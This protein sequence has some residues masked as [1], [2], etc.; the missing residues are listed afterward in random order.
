MVSADPPVSPP[1]P[2]AQWDKQQPDITSV[3]P[4]FACNIVQLAYSVFRDCEA[5]LLESTAG[6]RM[7]QQ[8]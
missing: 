5:L 3:S 7:A 6:P 8:R 1:F 4:V 2:H